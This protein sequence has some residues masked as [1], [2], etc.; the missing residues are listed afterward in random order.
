MLLLLLMNLDF[1]GGTAGADP[2]SAGTGAVVVGRAVVR[3][4]VILQKSINQIDVE[5]TKNS[6][7][8]S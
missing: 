7:E 6:L 5:P 1:A 3:S 8:V 4:G 2:P